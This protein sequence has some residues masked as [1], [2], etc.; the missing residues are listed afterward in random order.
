MVIQIE[1][2]KKCKNVLLLF[3]IIIKNKLIYATLAF[4]VYEPLKNF[5]KIY[6][7]DSPDQEL[8]KTCLKK[9]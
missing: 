1:L 9:F 3:K 2:K 7:I 4:P 5:T 8:F 6:S